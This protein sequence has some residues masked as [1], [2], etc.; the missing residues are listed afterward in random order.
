MACAHDP[1]S[2]QKGHI[3]ADGVIEEGLARMA[4]VSIRCRDDGNSFANEQDSVVI[5]LKRVAFSSMIGYVCGF[6]PRMQ[7]NVIAKS[8]G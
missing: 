1:R 4:G 3:D 7:K 6:E 5:S 2:G 8:E